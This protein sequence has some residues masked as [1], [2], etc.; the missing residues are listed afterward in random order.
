MK[1][2]LV[3]VLMTSSFIALNAQQQWCF[4]NLQACPQTPA[5]IFRPT[6][7]GAAPMPALLWPL[8]PYTRV[9]PLKPLLST[10]QFFV[11][12]YPNI[13]LTF[14]GPSLLRLDPFPVPAKRGVL[15][16]PQH[17]HGTQT[18]GFDITGPTFSKD[19]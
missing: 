4:S 2:A 13:M 12:S 7:A 10:Q 19:H 9:V 1:A 5:T 17:L 6:P 3:V 15:G 16:I 8:R 14:P 18:G 11:Y